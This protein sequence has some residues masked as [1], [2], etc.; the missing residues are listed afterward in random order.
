MT[1]LATGRQAKSRLVGLTGSHVPARC[2]RWQL[3]PLA[4]RWTSSPPW[5]HASPGPLTDSQRTISPGSGLASDSGIGETRFAASSVTPAPRPTAKLT[6]PARKAIFHAEPISVLS[7][8]PH[9]LS[10]R[11]QHQWSVSPLS[12]VG[13]PAYTWAWLSESSRV[14]WCSSARRCLWLAAQAAMRLVA[15]VVPFAVELRGGDPV[16]SER[17][18]A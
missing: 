10:P 15:E 7:H 1:G 2:A 16:I 17:R 4:G 5:R 6:A 9:L 8:V 12:T 18:R 14:L 13:G 11:L 3:C